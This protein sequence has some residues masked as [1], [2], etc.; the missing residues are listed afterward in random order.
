MSEDVNY[1]VAI[2]GE[3]FVYDGNPEAYIHQAEDTGWDMPEHILSH[4]LNR[5]EAQEIELGNLGSEHFEE[6]YGFSSEEVLNG[7]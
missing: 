2:L 1:E 4:E 5:I 7:N 6:M 3:S